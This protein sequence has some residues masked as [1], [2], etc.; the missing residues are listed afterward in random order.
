MINGALR[1]EVPGTGFDVSQTFLA[2]STLYILVPSLMVAFSLI[3]PARI[4]RPANLVVSLL[5]IAS[6]VASAVGDTWVYSVL[7]SLIEVLLLLAIAAVAWFW[8]TAPRS[9]PSSQPEEPARVSA[10]G[11]PPSRQSS[12]H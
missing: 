8:P 6:V 3:A 7:G 11:L 5:Y 12:S 4:N 9:L 10:A 2:L 1:H